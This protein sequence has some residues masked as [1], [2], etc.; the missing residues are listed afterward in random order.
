[1]AVFAVVLTALDLTAF[2]FVA[3]EISDN[4]EPLAGTAAGAAA[5]GA[6]LRR[7]ALTIAAFDVP[8]VAIV[9]AASYALATLS[10]RPFIAARERESRFV[11]DAAHELRTPLAAIAS[12]AQAAAPEDAASAEAFRS[13]ASTALRAAVLVGDLLAL[14]RET[15]DAPQFREP[16]ALG[17]LARAIV[18]ERETPS[19]VRIDIRAAR[20]C[21][22]L[23]DERRLRQAVANLLD[24][25]VRHAVSTVSISLDAAGSRA[26]LAIDDDGP[27]VLPAHH[28]QIFDRFF[29]TRPDGEGSGLGL[30]ICRWVARSHGGD[31]ILESGSRFVMSLPRE[32]AG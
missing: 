24:N 18:A 28:A 22:V 2:A 16:V 23:G 20:E 8:L 10:L 32:T 21:Y 11:A 26:L 5:S 12:R 15:E 13:I 9:A 14:V 25:A 7:L 3:R 17:A 27:G 30:A 4:L 19:A 31:V 6:A 1:M 29:T